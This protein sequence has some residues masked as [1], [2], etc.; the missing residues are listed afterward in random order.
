MPS[1]AI[2]VFVKNPIE[3]R[4]KTRIAA[5]AGHKKAVEV[6]KK[7][8]RY[9]LEMLLDLR[10]NHDIDCKI[11]LYYG[12]EINQD[13]IWN[14][15]ADQ[16]QIQTGN[17]LGERMYNAFAEQFVL[18]AAKVLIIGSDCP[19]ITASHLKQAFNALDNYPI[20]FGPA[21]DGGYYLL[22]MKT[23]YK[24]IFNDK[25]WSQPNLLTNT[26]QELAP[27]SYYLLEKLSD[28]D[29][30]EDYLQHYQ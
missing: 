11:C 5:V 22:G 20:V 6:Y 8:L 25:P 26:L 4:V 17:D 18:G 3:G 14:I 13:D 2:I 28:I 10:R 16:K 7:L 30:W 1:H 12:D 15:V 23:L 24:N 27:D 21:T 29:T 9:T 19:T